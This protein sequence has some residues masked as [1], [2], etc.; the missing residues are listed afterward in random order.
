[1][2]QR[3]LARQPFRNFT[4]RIAASDGTDRY[5]SSSGKPVFDQD[6]VFV[7]YRGVGRDMTEAVETAHAITRAREQAEA[8]NR[9]KSRFLA[10]MSHELRTPMTGVLG[11]MD[12]LSTTRLS[13]EQSQWLDIMRTSAQTLMKVLNDILD[14]SKIEADQIK[15]ESIDFPLQQVVLEVVRLF[16]RSALNKGVVLDSE[17]QGLEDD[18][19]VRG[20]P[21]RLRQVLLNLVGNAVKFTERG[22]IVIRTSALASENEILTVRFEV[23]DTG[24]GIGEAERAHLFQAFSQA[25]STTTRRF[26]GTGLGLA[27]CRRLVEG[28][29]GTIGLTSEPGTG[30]TFWFTVPLG[31]VATRQLAASDAR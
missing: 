5:V 6:G 9:A 13:A 24:I 14:F 12:L 31:C 25:D 21:T 16:E 10:V 4:Y 19:I 7:G 22:R 1:M 15:F 3:L 26:G 30:S 27:I 11:T 28:M 18:R 23:Q 29:G 17:T 2:R 8:A 20:D